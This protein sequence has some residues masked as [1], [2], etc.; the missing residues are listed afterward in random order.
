MCLLISRMGENGA[1]MGNAP[2]AH[3][4]PRVRAALLGDVTAI[5]TFQTE[6]WREAYCGIVPPDYLNRV[7]E[8]DRTLRWHERL[9][10]GAREIALA[11]LDK[12][13]LG[14]VSWGATTVTDAPTLELKSLYV[15][16][17]QRGRGLAATLLHA[18]VGTRPAHLWV[19][20]D[21]P[22]AHA[23]YAKHG[24]A[25]DGRRQRDP[26]TGLREQRWVRP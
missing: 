19:F 26:D 11:E 17:D 6:C 2:N 16:A 4:S 10:S 21:N 20:E 14:V 25:F 23:F 12:V 13:M 1:V 22:R 24:F 15:A 9:V 18:S 3:G 8:A 7:G 5:A